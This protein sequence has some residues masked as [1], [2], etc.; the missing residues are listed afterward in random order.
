METFKK[1][2]SMGVVKKKSKPKILT[3][4]KYIE[5]I[6]KIIQRDFFP[7][8]EKLKAQNDYLD[9]LEQKDYARMESIRAK[10]SGRKPTERNRSM[11]PETFDS[12]E[13]NTCTSTA[14]TT[15]K[16]TNTSSA[17]DNS[18]SVCDNHTLDSFLQAYTSEDNDSF[19][20]IVDTA[21][22]KLRQ[23]FAVLYNEETIS[24]D[25]LQKALTL[26]SIEQ[27]FEEPDPM[28]KIETWTYQNKNSIMYTP[29][30]VELT[31][32]E[33]IDMANR[34]QVIQH[35]ATR[36]HINPFEGTQ[37]K[38]TEEQSAETIATPAKE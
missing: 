4:E 36:L 24:A 27:Q 20:K 17:K 11:T 13:F 31:E 3:E 9:A 15:S 32:A 7:D 12:F 33:K 26:P 23:K 8:L 29:D 25:K 1:P 6:S 18:K 16:A 34:K 5:E 22:A 10:Y 19:Q 37:R 38:R 14:T 2:M 35:S 21:D 30:G 28:R